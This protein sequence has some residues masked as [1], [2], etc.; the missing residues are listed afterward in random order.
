MTPELRQ[1]IDEI[2]DLMW[3]VYGYV[4]DHG[5]QLAEGVSSPAQAVYLREL[6]HSRNAKHIGEIGFNIGFSAV[7]F[8]ESAPDTRV[9]SFELNS[10]PAVELAKEFIDMRYPGRHRLIIGNSMET[11]PNYAGDPLDL[12]FVDGGHEYD[13]VRADIR[14]ARAIAKPG[15]TVVVDDII[16]WYPWGRG[17]H[18]AWQEAIAEGLLTPAEYHLDGRPVDEITEPGDRAW[19]TGQFLP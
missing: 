13:T 17:P 8:L 2:E 15:A 10:R 3:S 18:Q 9:V 4:R 14:N 6:A 7:A 12:A 1:R 5:G 16:P 19:G 11:V